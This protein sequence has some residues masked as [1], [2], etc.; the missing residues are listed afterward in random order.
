M[1]GRVRMLSN[2]G[3]LWWSSVDA[4]IPALRYYPCA[5]CARV[6]RLCPSVCVCVDKKHA[7][8][9]L[10]ARKSPQKLSLQLLHWIYS[11]KKTL[12][13]LASLVRA[14][15]SW[16]SKATCPCK[17]TLRY[18][19]CVTQPPIDVLTQSHHMYSTSEPKEMR[20][21]N[22]II[23]TVSAFLEAFCDVPINC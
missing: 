21:Q 1:A 20:A 11:H 12:S 13:V 17:S 3:A 6:M 7:C 2:A 14:A 8:L 10:T 16:L 18:C 4:K 9:R 23:A 22:L 15:N 19:G 5:V